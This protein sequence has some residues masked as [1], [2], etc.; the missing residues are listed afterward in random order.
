MPVCRGKW[1]KQKKHSVLETDCSCVHE[2]V[3]VSL[4]FSQRKGLENG[5]NSAWDT[6]D[7][8]VA[9]RKSKAKSRAS[10]SNAYPI[11]IDLLKYWIVEN[12]F[13][14]LSLSYQDR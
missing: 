14:L 11:M 12:E 7:P 4:Y 9:V 8:E 13:N 3:F 2:S 5:E 1:W 6:S 10:D